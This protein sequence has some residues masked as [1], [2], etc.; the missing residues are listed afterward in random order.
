M[1]AVVIAGGEETGGFVFEF[2]NGVN[3]IF[4]SAKVTDLLA[5]ENF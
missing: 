5:L 2:Q 4:A 1:Q 3:G